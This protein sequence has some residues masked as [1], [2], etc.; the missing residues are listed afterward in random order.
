MMMMVI[1]K[2]VPQLGLFLGLIQLNHI[3][4]SIS[5]GISSIRI[6]SVDRGNIISIIIIINFMDFNIITITISPLL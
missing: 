4:S 5:I 6:D 3:I 1:V 2:K